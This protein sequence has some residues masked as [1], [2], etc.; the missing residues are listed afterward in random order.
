MINTK[1]PKLKHLRKNSETFD[2]YYSARVMGLNAEEPSLKMPG[3]H[4]LYMLHRVKRQTA[5]VA[6]TAVPGAVTQQ[7]ALVTSGSYSYLQD[8]MT[9]LSKFLKHDV[10]CWA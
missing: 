5:T 6:P 10:S 9:I 4:P 2:F 1:Y 8:S 3:K 7:P